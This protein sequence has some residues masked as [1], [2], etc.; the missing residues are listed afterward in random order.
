MPNTE[1]P[2][3]EPGA[4]CITSCQFLGGSADFEETDGIFLS[5]TLSCPGYPLGV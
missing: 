5:Y 3:A 1:D 4:A 2:D